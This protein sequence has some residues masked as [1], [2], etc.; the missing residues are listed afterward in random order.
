MTSSHWSCAERRRNRACASAC[1]VVFALLL[2]AAL[3]FPATAATGERI[4]SVGDDVITTSEFAA[5]LNRYARQ[6]LYHGGSRAQLERLA[7][8]ALDTMITEKLLAHA[9]AKRGTRGEPAKV[10]A[11]IE[12][13]RDQ[14]SGSES[15]E[16]IEPRLDE[17]ES[18]LLLDTRIT[19]LR[20]SVT[21]VRDPDEDA[22]RAFY[23]DNLDLFMR[24]AAYDVDLILIGV[25]PSALSEEWRNA[26]V[27]ADRVHETLEAG[28]SFAALAERHSTHESA[29]SGGAVGRIHKGQLP[30]AAQRALEALPPGGTSKPVKALE[31]YLILRLNARFEAEQRP[32][33]AVSE[34]A[35]ALY[36]RERAKAQWTNFL[37]DLRAETKVETYDVD[38]KLQKLLSAE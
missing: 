5:F 11:E 9:V 17:I 21:A 27:K 22:V 20:E 19:A 18:A 31:G 7:R 30:D 37:E 4:A 33:E 16:Q 34:R 3:A 6:K 14:Y 1:R 25:A 15:W 12:R 35:K 29:E 23:E 38:R 26:K 32:Y 36:I 10:A 8:E 2:S 13:L 28:G 24:P